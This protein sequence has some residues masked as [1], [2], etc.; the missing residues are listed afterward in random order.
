VDV[1]LK[2]TRTDGMYIFW[3][4]S[5]Q[6]G[7]NLVDVEG[8]CRVRFRFEPNIF[9]AGD[10]HVQIDLG[11]GYDVERNFPQSEIF[12]RR[13]DA[14]RFTVTREWPILNLG[15]LNYVFPVHVTGAQTVETLPEPVETADLIRTRTLHT[16][17][18]S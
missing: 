11:N 8:T 18:R 17:P 2:L 14:L 4:S 6:A 16:T 3:Q 5:G 10:Y 13:V 7:K 9:G 15:P 1:G 12:D